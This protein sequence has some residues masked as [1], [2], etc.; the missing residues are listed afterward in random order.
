MEMRSVK[1]KEVRIVVNEGRKI[2]F[3]AWKIIA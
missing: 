3:T 2:G 1:F